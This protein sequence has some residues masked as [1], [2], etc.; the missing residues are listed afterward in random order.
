M[1]YS[2]PRKSLHLCVECG[3]QFYAGRSHA[4]TCSVNCRKKLSLKR[5]AIYDFEAEFYKRLYDLESQVND[6]NLGA[7]AFYVLNEIQRRVCKASKRVGK[8]DMA[9]QWEIG[10]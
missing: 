9:K 4:K 3:K 2:E 5:Q 10:A 1:K 7:D 6:P 8:S